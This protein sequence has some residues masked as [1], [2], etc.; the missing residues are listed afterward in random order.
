M[1]RQRNN[2]FFCI[3]VDST[4][5]ADGNYELVPAS[6]EE[7]RD[8]HVAWTEATEDPGQHPK[9]FAPEPGASPTNFN[10]MHITVLYISFLCIYVI[11]FVWNPSCIILGTDE[12]NLVRVS[13]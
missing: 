11:G 1:L 13:R 7:N 3:H 4:T 6:E 5:L 8:A 10:V 2:T 9:V 12:V